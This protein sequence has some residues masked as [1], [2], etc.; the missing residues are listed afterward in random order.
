M[1]GGHID[2]GGQESRPRFSDF[3]T[4][5]QGHPCVCAAAPGR[6]CGRGGCVCAWAGAGGEG[7]ETG[8]SGGLAGLVPRRYIIGTGDLVGAPALLLPGHRPH[9]G[10]DRYPGR[11]VAGLLLVLVVGLLRPIDLCP[12]LDH[13]LRTLI[14][15]VLVPRHA[16]YFGGQL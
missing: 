14:A 12:G 7:A 8:G 1:R 13:Y 4:P 16:H 15:S 3:G 11:L 5:P 2:P 9:P 6:V 10:P